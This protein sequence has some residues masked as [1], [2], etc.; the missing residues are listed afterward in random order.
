MRYLPILAAVVLIALLSA[1]QPVQAGWN[2]IAKESAG[3]DGVSDHSVTKAIID[4]KNADPGMHIFFRKAYGYAVFPKV[5]KAGIG[6]GG[7]YGKGKVY[8]KGRFIGLTSLAQ[9]TIG[10]QLGVQSYSE[11]I[12]FKDKAALKNFTE[13]NLELGAQVSA[14][15]VTSGASANADYS[16]GV[17][18]FTVTR[19]GLMYEASVGGQKFSYTPVP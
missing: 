10:F 13:G 4:F 11:I 9:V 3:K 5:G 16:D 15:A 18:I 7:A 1:V 19:G 17:A 2:P 6:I 14:V 8:K 12:F